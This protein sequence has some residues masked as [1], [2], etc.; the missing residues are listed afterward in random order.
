MSGKDKTNAASDTSTPLPL[1]ARGKNKNLLTFYLS[2][3]TRKAGE[4]NLG[5]SQSTLI[6]CT[7]L[8]IE[9]ISLNI[10]KGILI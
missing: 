10:K 5:E 2:S 6:V 9:V 7:E 3:N 8:K 4:A 1:S